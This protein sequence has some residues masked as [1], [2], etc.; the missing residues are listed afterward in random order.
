M[1]DRRLSDEGEA[2]TPEPASEPA[3][4]SEQEQEQE[5]EPDEGTAYIRRAISEL[6]SNSVERR[7]FLAGYAYVLVRVA[8]ADG[9]I[10]DAEIER[11][12]QAI[13]AAG[14]VPEA[15][16]ALVVALASRLNSLYG[17]T[18]DYAVTRELARASS[19]QERQRLLRACVAVGV[20]DGRLTGGETAELH[21]VGRELGF[22]V[23][24][25]EAVRQQVDPHVSEPPEAQA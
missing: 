11:M 22:S 13:I 9:E 25:I 1:F 21:E 4:G 15:V 18:D 24:E 8:R 20:A 6:G 23:E 3:P 19:P 16:G 2:D 14:D 10:K 17:A 12:E 5:Q 7:R